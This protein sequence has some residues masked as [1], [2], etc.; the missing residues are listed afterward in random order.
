MA[1]WPPSVNPLLTPDDWVFDPTL[2]GVWECADDCGQWTFEK[3]GDKGYEL[4]IVE[5]EAQARL[6][7]RLGQLDGEFFLQTWPDDLNLK[8]GIVAVHVVPHY[9]FS[10][11][12]R[13]GAGIELAGMSSDW[14]ADAI[15]ANEVSIAHRLLEDDFVVL[16][17]ATAEL[18]RFFVD[19]SG[20]PKAFPTTG[21][22]SVAIRLTRVDPG[23]AP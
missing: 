15:E 18:R 21:R 7:A 22:G 17:A 11:V 23:R 9:A 16:T 19:K 14:L 5:D 2:L 1:C 6:D 13:S 12:R 8:P 20:D 3:D 10:R 4:T